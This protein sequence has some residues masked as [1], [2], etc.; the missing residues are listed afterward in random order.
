MIY[1]YVMVGSRKFRKRANKIGQKIMKKGFQVKL[2][3]EPAPRIDV[4]GVDVLRKLKTKYQREHFEAIRYCKRGIIVCNFNG[5]V[6]LNTKAEMIF[7]HAYD[8]P[9]FSVENVNSDE[10]E[11]E[12][13]QIRRLNLTNF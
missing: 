5:Y 10:E 8:V 6:G 7:S 1:D 11:L 12:I 9:I 13:M 3:S 2:I 4:D